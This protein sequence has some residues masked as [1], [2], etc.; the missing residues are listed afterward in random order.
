MM[1]MPL[2]VLVLMGLV[3]GMVY[4]V[5]VLLLLQLN[6]W[7]GISLGLIFFRHRKYQVA[8]NSIIFTGLSC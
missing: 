7:E 8:F 4:L 6:S 1:C 3:C 5:S 2:I